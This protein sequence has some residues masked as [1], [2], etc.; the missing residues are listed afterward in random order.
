MKVI[1]RFKNI[2]LSE[3]LKRTIERK[4][5]SLKKFIGILKKEEGGKTLAQVVVD[6]ERETKHH[7]KGKIFKVSLRISLPGRNLFYLAQEDDLP[8]AI[9]KARRG[10]KEEIE[11]YQFRLKDKTKK[12]NFK[13]RSDENF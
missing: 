8:K 11:K 7:R 13:E 5:F 1:L 10:M 6:I 4:I 2:T 9:T 3:E 12:K